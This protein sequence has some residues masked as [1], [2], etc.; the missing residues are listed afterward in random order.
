DIYTE[1]SLIARRIIHV[2]KNGCHTINIDDTKKLTGYNSD[3]FISYDSFSEVIDLLDKQELEGNTV[4]IINKVD[5][6]EQYQQIIDVISKK[7][8]KILPVLQHPNSF[9]VLKKTNPSSIDDITQTINNSDVVILVDENP[10][11]YLD[12][13]ILGD[14]KV[15][16]LKTIKD[17]LDSEIEIPVKAWYEQT[18]SFTNNAG[19][20]QEFSDALQTETSSLKTITEIVDQIEGKI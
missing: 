14:K 6:I 10:E 1:N 3:E 18:G 15:I 16:S 20:E 8:M 9:S 13:T 2:V 19:I 11:E 17:S 5:S 12:T 7:N 4:V